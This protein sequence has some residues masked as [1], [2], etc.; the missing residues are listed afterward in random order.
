MKRIFLI[1]LIVLFAGFV[2]A[3]QLQTGIERNQSGYKEITFTLDST[4]TKTV[5][6]AFPSARVGLQ[7]TKLD[8]AALG[9]GLTTYT[10][11][12]FSGTGNMFLSIVV[13]SLADDVL[14]SLASWMKPY[15]FN[16]TKEA[17]Y[18][19]A[20]DSTFLIWDT[21][22]DYTATTIDYLNWTH[23]KCY[24]IQLSN[25]LWQCGGLAIV[26]RQVAAH[27]A[28]GATRVYF[29]LWYSL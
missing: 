12:E 4:S 1:G 3:Q 22:N 21:V 2:S 23:G 27:T 8:T 29:A 11:G 16:K 15:T 24:T 26:F 7:S 13:D 19:S 28:A 10:E 18:Q 5:Y 20:N 17:W 9:T 6:I 25:E 14:D